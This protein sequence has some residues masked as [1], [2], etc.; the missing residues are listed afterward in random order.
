MNFSVLNLFLKLPK[1]LLF[2][3][4]STC[5][6]GFVILF[7]AGGNNLDPWAYKQ[8]INFLIFFPIMILVAYSDIRLIYKYSYI[9]Y[10]SIIILLFA[11]HFFGHTAMGATRW[12]S[13]GTVKIQP[14]EPAKLAVIVFLAKYF[15][16]TSYDN[17]NKLRY[18][19]PPILA[20][21]IPAALIIKQPDL[22]TGI[23]VLIISSIL[24]FSSGVGVKK[25]VI[26]FAIILSFS[27]I[28]WNKMHDYQ[29]KRVEVFLNPDKDPLGSGYNIIQSKIAIG[30]GGLFG[31]GLGEGTQSH[32]S[33]LPEHQTDFI[34]ACLS[35][36]LG[37]LGAA[38]LIILYISII[39]ISL[40][41]SINSKS[42]YNKLLSIGVTSIFFSHAMINIGM[43]SGIFPVVGIPLPLVSY[44]GTMMGSM[45]IGFGIIM[46]VHMNQ[47]VKL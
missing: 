3:V 26:L 46:N 4:I 35:E 47:Q 39:Y 12:L 18:L 1:F 24:F 14:S 32:L 44:G 2:L 33:F 43:V 40:S 9:F 45:L 6:Y 31:R 22:G 20:V 28:I 38:I 41:I 29:K 23:V 36:D 34:F 25:F 16:N 5:S 10:I 13:I 8:I 11:V 27:P 37:F 21:I 15:H 30:S 7:S 19:I 42:L 17:L